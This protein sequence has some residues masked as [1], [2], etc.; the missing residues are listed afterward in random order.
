MTNTTLTQFPTGQTQYKINFDYLSRQ[1]VVVTLIN[2][3]NTISNKVLVAGNDYL[4]L[5]PT[6]LQILAPQEGFD[7][8]QIHRVTSVDSVVDFRDGSVLTARDLTNSELQAIHIAE[9]GRDQT[10]DLAKQYADM[11]LESRNDAEEFKDRVEEVMSQGM[12]GYILLDSFQL[13]ATLSLTNHAL[14]WTKPDGSGE[15]YRWDGELPKVVPAGSTP[16]STGGIALGAWV[17]VGDASLRSLLYS[18]LGSGII[19]REEGGTLQSSFYTVTPQM[20]GAVGDG[21]ADD[22]QAIQDA[23]SSGHDVDFGTGRYKVSGYFKI[24]RPGTRLLSSGSIIEQT[25]WGYP[26][27]VIQAKGVKMNGTWEG[28]Y[29]GSRSVVIESNTLGFPYVTSGDWKAYG[30]FIWMDYYQSRDISGFEV[31]DLKVYGFIGGIWFTGADAR[32][33]SAYFDTVDF[34]VFGVVFD[35]QRI[36]S[37]YH[38]NITASQGHEGHAVYT[39]GTGKGFYCG[40]VYVEGSPFAGS[41]VKI[42]RTQNFRIE[43][44]SGVGLA[45]VA[46]FM[47]GTTGTVGS[48]NC[49]C[50]LNA[51]FTG[52]GQAPSNYNLL[53]SGEGTSVTFTGGVNI[54]ANQQGVVKAAAVQCSGSG[55]ELIFEGAFKY[56]NTNSSPQQP[57]AAFTTSGGRVKFLGA[58]TVHHPNSLCTSYI[59][60]LLGDSGSVWEVPPRVIVGAASTMPLL[61]YTSDGTGANASWSFAYDPAL[62]F[63]G[64]NNQSIISTLNDYWGVR[65][66]GNCRTANSLTSGFPIV[67]HTAL[68]VITQTATTNLSRLRYASPGQVLTL[69]NGGNATNITHNT[70]SG[71]DGNIVTPTGTTILAANWKYATFMKIGSDMHCI[72]FR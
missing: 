9:E 24:D 64:V 31:D 52:P 23:I 38:K 41:P 67:T 53:A 44:I 3:V 68:A 26:V 59:F 32:I 66:R 58:C 11:A 40:P 12:Y 13:G 27:F 57:S 63:P 62:I 16:D 35:N 2:S 36:G 10:A 56:I 65:F 50:D 5:N 14:K 7:I 18:N 61:R 60:N 17:S 46:Y 45:T 72:N 25:L 51:N 43:S 54:T 15:Y 20:F 70:Q 30:C 55:A 37:V 71:L 49:I 42:H 28:R 69:V 29:E 4:F 48:V 33:G 1:F 22:T 6:T 47:E 21:I 39:N 19:G 8:I 34:G